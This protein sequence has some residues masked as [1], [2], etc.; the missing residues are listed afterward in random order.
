MIKIWIRVLFQF[1]GGC[2]FVDEGTG[3]VD[4]DDVHVETKTMMSRKRLRTRSR[5]MTSRKRLRIRS[6]TMTLSPVS[7]ESAETSTD[8]SQAKPSKR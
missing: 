7:D 2:R 6:R 3:E 4:S 8:E 5:T 1:C